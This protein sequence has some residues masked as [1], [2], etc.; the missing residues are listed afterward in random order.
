[1]AMNK[2]QRLM[3]GLAAGQSAETQKAKSRFDRA[4]TLMERRPQGLG[5]PIPGVSPAAQAETF[6]GESKAGQGAPVVLRVPLD[7]LDDNPYNAR[8]IYDPA[9]VKELAAELATQ[10]QRVPANAV[11]GRE[12]GR[13]IVIDGHYRKLGAKMAG[14]GHL[15]I[16][17]GPPISDAEMY[18][19]SF[20]L[21]EHRRPN[22][23][24]DNAL[25]WQALLESKVVTREEDLAALTGVSVANV[26]K[27][28]SLLRLPDVVLQRMRENVAKF[29]IAVG[30]ELTL[31]FKIAGDVETAK[32]VDRVVTEELSKRDVEELRKQ[33]EQ[34]AQREQGP[35]RKQ[36][37]VSRQYRIRTGSDQIGILKEWANSG[38]VSLDVKMTDP[39]KRAELVAELKERFH[40]Q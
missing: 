28:L 15:D 13:W 25:A 8:R 30:Y 5:D 17:V 31:Y 16:I 40:L 2:T 37:E 6:T 3:S 33:R 36:K 29:G 39:A 11:T 9:V 26:N 1:M 19:L 12:P 32:L 4:D 22:S 7:Q 23:A 10:G 24:L 27:T 38:R 14:I 34:R 21:N 20:S 35:G 18:Q